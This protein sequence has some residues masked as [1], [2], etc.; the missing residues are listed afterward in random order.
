MRRYSVEKFG[1]HAGIKRNRLL[2]AWIIILAHG[3]YAAQFCVHIRFGRANFP[4][5]FAKFG[6]SVMLAPGFESLYVYDKSFCRK[7]DE[8]T[9]SPTPE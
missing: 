1:L 7:L 4:D 3:A 5:D 6:N 9:C 8:N 2:G